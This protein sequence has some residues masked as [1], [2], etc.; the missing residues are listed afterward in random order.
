MTKAQWADAL[1]GRQLRHRRVH[2][3][4]CAATGRPADRRD[5]A[6]V[7]L[8]GVVA[9]LHAVRLVLLTAIETDGDGCGESQGGGGGADAAV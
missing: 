3:D 7:H 5:G 1:D 9:K 6:H 2:G 8:L 4:E